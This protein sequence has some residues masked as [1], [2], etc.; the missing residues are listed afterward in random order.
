MQNELIVSVVDSPDELGSL[1]DEWDRLLKESQSP[2]ICSS[3]E[4]LHTWWKTYGNCGVALQ[5]LRV[6]HGDRLVGLAPFFLQEQRL[7]RF[8]RV[9]TM[10]FLGTGEPERDEV[11][12]EYLD[13][14]ALVGW[15]EEVAR[16][17]WAHLRRLGSWDQLILN[18][19]LADSLVMTTLSRSMAGD[20]LPVSSE[21]VGI[22]YCVDL[23]LTWDAYL[24]KLES[25][26]AKRLSYKRRKLER[27]GQV[28]E[29]TIDKSQ[30]LEQAFDELVR[31]HTAR[32][33]S[34][35]K[36]GV[37][38]SPRFTAYHKALALLLLPRDMLRMRLLLL[39]DVTIAVLYN[40]RFHGTE[41]FYQGGFDV[42]HAAKYS[43]GLLAHVYAIIN[44]IQ[45]RMGRYDFM[46]G[47]TVS[48]KTEYGCAEQPM[49]DVQVFARTLFGR[50]L[51]AERW[52]RKTL[53]LLRQKLRG[54]APA[55]TK[56]D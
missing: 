13:I 50:A 25:S 33:N 12:S 56:P 21:E 34:Q 17:V 46:K 28:S 11:A 53:G 7:F 40:F 15:E 5:L 52:G 16:A 47:G 29:R 20:G 43:P 18:D 1:R 19:V 6:Q 31:Q 45:G 38:A 36:Q 4:W 49:Y 3:W 22:R 54:L 37:F 51:R 26:A 39:D 10:R 30:E 55:S 2:S 9:R 23:P 48:Y 27:A 42:A 35:D 32:W 14:L 41:Y 44:S 8:F 24:A